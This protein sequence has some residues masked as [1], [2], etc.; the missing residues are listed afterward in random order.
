MPYPMK[1]NT[2]KDWWAVLKMKSRPTI[3]APEEGPPF[4]VDENENP[5]SLTDI[6]MEDDVDCISNQVHDAGDVDDKEKGANLT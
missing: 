3:D 2:R 6:D 1:D 5:P 4:Q